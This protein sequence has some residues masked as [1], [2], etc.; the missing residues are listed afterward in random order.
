[1]VGHLSPDAP[2]GLR[3]PSLPSQSAPA[4]EETHADRAQSLSEAAVYE[5]DPK[6]TKRVSLM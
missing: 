2:G 5:R 3:P 1:M 4:P 6:A